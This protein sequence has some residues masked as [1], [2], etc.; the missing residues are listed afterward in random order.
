MTDP[1]HVTDWQP[2]F[3]G[4]GAVISP[5]KRPKQ[6]LSDVR[7]DGCILIKVC[8]FPFRKHE[9]MRLVVF[10]SGAM[11]VFSVWWQWFPLSGRCGDFLCQGSRYGLLRKHI[12]KKEGNLG[13]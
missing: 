13:D 8:M 12:Y 3:T 9:E 5:P 4:L 11:L 7:E 10:I 1:L 2:H 6:N